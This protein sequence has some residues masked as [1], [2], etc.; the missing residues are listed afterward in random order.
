MLKD[1][2]GMGELQ[3]HVR[4]VHTSAVSPRDACL[5]FWHSVQSQEELL[6]HSL[7]AAGFCSTGNP[8]SADLRLSSF[9]R[10]FIQTNP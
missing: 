4:I 5:W 9:K 10:G 8:T 6:P 1:D 7:A 2:R 3:V